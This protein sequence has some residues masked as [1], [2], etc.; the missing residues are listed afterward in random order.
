VKVF[1]LQIDSY[2]I[3]HF[4]YALFGLAG[5]IGTF[6]LGRW[7]YGPLAG[8]LSAL[9]LTLIPAYYG[10]MFM[11]PKD[12]PF[13]AIHVLSLYFGLRVIFSLPR[14]PWGLSLGFGLTL[15]VL[16]GIK[17][18]GGVV[19]IYVLVGLALALRRCW[20]TLTKETPPATLWL[21]IIFRQILPVLVI[22]W[23]VMLIPWPWAWLDPIGNPIKAVI[24]FSNFSNWHN[25][26]M[27]FG[28]IF[29]WNEIPWY[30]VPSYFLL[31]LPEFI[32]LLLSIGT[33]LLL[34]HWKSFSTRVR[35]SIIV[36]LLATFF[37]LAFSIINKSV[38][39]GALR[40]F[41]F[42]LPLVS[43][44]SGV[45]AAHLINRILKRPI[46]IQV[47]GVGVLS[48]AFAL[49]A[50]TMIRLHPYEYIFF[51]QLIGGYAGAHGRME[52]D[53][54]STSYREAVEKLV[55]HVK[56][57]EPDSPPSAPK[58]VFVCQHP[59]N[60]YHY[61]SPQLELVTDKREADFLIVGLRNR[62]LFSIQ[63]GKIVAKVE[64]YDH[65][66]ALVREIEQQKIQQ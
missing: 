25:T 8:F 3:A 62:C 58:K 26:V 34:F 19:G 17:S 20:G 41:S 1:G 61:F 30:Y 14:A 46:M 37:L 6:L 59:E 51:N 22:A 39:Y 45:T 56:K 23:L 10:P 43:I 42:M 64:R 53:Y 48:M 32:L 47:A 29:Q 65:P 12:I 21:R 60:A 38:V 11:N 16:M 9:C 28:E 18:A 57:K 33:G 13:A 4:A 36:L 24:G 52:S 54:W 49:Q 50:Y 7:L 15:G 66:L 2:D 27:V 31:Q 44:F 63:D 5:I 55:D 35:I 40:H